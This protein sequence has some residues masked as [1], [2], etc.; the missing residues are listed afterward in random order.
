M[1]AFVACGSDKK[2]LR[3]NVPAEVRKAE[4]GSYDL[5]KYEVVDE[6]GLI[7]AGYTV[8]VESAVDPDGES[9]TVAYNKINAVKTG[10]YAITYTAGAEIEK[11]VL[12]VDFADRTA[13]KVDMAENALP[14]YYI[15]GFTY[16]LPT[17]SIIDEPDLSKCWIKVFYKAS[18]DA[19]QIEIAVENSRF[20]VEHNSGRY[21]V[22]IHAED[23]AGNGK[24][25]EYEVDAVGPSEIV[26][27]KVLYFDE[28]FGVSQVKT[29]WNNFEI[30]YGTEKTYGEEAGSTKVTSP[31]ES[32]DYIILD[33]II[34]SDVSDY[35]HLV[36]RIYN[37]NDFEA[38][39]GYCWFGDVTLAPHAW[40]EL[41]I[42]VSDLDTKNVSHPAVAGIVINS[43]N[44]AN[45][46]LR[47]FSDYNTN[48]VPAGSTFYFSAMYAVVEAPTEP[49]TVVENKIA[50]FD[51]AFGLE[52][53]ALYWSAPHKL[54]LDTEIKYGEEKGSLKVEVVTAQDNYIVLSLPWIKDVSA[55]DYLVFR[56]YNPTDKTF[57][58]GTTWAA[59]TVIAANA[60]TEVR[61]PV[62]LFGEGKIT[63]MDGTVLSATDVAGLPL[64]IF[65]AETLEIGDCFYISAVYGEN[66]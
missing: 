58:M 62:A 4:L 38:Y 35:T 49:E 2:K 22:V 31:Q 42:P 36:V 44:I 60:W 55:Y 47:L 33:R 32:G 64:R 59:D 52:Q 6:N 5:P 41:K 1:L 18:A 57:S 12:R 23:A 21:I 15:V 13:P 27:G 20:Q 50:Y 19:E 14:A 61:I 43:E 10:I 8:E 45:L 37:D 9:V 26:E 39:S 30:S 54:S 7:M 63:N 66:N 51:E 34:Q 16:D 40:T 65:G 48:K 24:D 25:Y 46:S 3:I 11:A 28:A 17:Y 53:V 29:L 56:V